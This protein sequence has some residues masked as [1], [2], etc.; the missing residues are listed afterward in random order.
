[1]SRAEGRAAVLAEIAARYWELV[2]PAGPSGIRGAEGIP[3]PPPT[4]TATVKEF[5]RLLRLLRDERHNRWWHV[6]EY[7]LRAETRPRWFCS[8]CRRLTH[9]QEHRHTD[10]RGREYTVAGRRTLHVVR[11]KNADRKKAESG[12]QWMASR[13]GLDHEPMLPAEILVYQAAA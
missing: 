9:Q 6:S 10:A 4:Y 8:K 5:E 3:F 7:W 13:W 11:H 12:I 1:M 2:E